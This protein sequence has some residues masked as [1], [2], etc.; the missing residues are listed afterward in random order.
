M[1]CFRVKLKADDLEQLWI[2]N[3]A[4]EAEAEAIAVSEGGAI[5]NPIVEIHQGEEAELKTRNL[6]PGQAAQ[7]V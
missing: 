1:T 6:G 7:W 4:S 2:V 5:P 3:A